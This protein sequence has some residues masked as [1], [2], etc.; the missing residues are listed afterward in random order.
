MLKLLGSPHNDLS[1]QR[2]THFA[3]DRRIELLDLGQDKDL[4]LLL[5]VFLL[6]IAFDFV[7]DLFVAAVDKGRQMD[8]PLLLDGFAGDMD[9]IENALDTLPF[10]I[11][12]R[13]ESRIDI[14]GDFEIEVEVECRGQF[15]PGIPLY[16][17]KII[18]FMELFDLAEERLEKLVFMTVGI[19]IDVVTDSETDT[20]FIRDIKPKVLPHKI[21]ITITFWRV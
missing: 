3:D 12:N 2:I 9:L 21:D 19:G 11:E 13:Y 18:R 4:S 8:T 16:Q 1:I 6:K 15:S 5:F 17:N 14:F 7:D 20:G 10:G